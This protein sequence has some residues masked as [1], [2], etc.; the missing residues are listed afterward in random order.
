[1]ADDNAVIVDDGETIVFDPVDVRILKF[2]WGTK[3]LN[4][5][6]TISTTVIT[7][8]ALRPST[9]DGL[10]AGSNTVLSASPYSSRWT[11]VTLTAGGNSKLGQHFEVANK[12]TTSDGETLERSCYVRIE[13]R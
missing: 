10:T 1:M 13:Q 5:G 8:T 11:T 7:I 9:A 6:V 12:I 4:T 3:R 2:D